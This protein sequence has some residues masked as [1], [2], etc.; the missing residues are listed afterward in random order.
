MI[1]KFCFHIFRKL[2][3]D[4]VATAI[5]SSVTPK[6][7]TLLSCPARTPRNIYEWNKITDASQAPDTNVRISGASDND[8]TSPVWPV[9]EVHC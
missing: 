4:P 7:D 8:I 3:H 5:P 2:S 6:H 9:N 1:K